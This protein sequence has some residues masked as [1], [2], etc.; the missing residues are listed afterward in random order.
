MFA[1]GSGC[2]FAHSHSVHLN[3]ASKSQFMIR[4]ELVTKSLNPMDMFSLHVL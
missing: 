1:I 4:S 3:L 2:L